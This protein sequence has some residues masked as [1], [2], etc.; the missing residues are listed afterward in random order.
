MLFLSN[1]ASRSSE[2]ELK[3]QH[4]VLLDLV[5]GASHK[6]GTTA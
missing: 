2:H 1:G 5:A 6:T 4:Q 3:M